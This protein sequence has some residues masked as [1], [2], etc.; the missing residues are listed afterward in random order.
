MNCIYNNAIIRTASAVEIQT[1][2][3]TSWY[4]Y[5]ER[6]GLNG[7]IHLAPFSPCVVPIADSEQEKPLQIG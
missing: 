1:T 4:H 7:K 2:Y 3:N 6:Q 5:F